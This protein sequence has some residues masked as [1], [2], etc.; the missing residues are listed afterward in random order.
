MVE[1]IE[2]RIVTEHTNK[3]TRKELIDVMKDR[4]VDLVADIRL[5]TKFPL[6]GRF[7]PDVLKVDL[8]KA[9]IK[10][11]RMKDLGNE[12]KDVRPME[13]SKRLYLGDAIKQKNYNELINILS[14]GTVKAC[15][16]CY[17]E[18]PKPCHRKWL[19]EQLCT[20]FKSIE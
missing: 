14:S 11:M 17:C 1:T 16:I 7:R 3:R 12:F 20:H 19:Q 8:E 13:E 5:T 9:G 15:L 4:G 10:Y 6:D 2:Q 18:P